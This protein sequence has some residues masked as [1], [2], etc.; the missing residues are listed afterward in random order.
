VLG[1][2]GRI[3]M[4]ISSFLLSQ[5]GEACIWKYILGTELKAFL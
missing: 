3:S 4:H 1:K 2:R 5:K